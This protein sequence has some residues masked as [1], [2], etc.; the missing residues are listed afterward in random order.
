MRRSH[1]HKRKKI[2]LS[3]A[4][5]YRRNEQI[6]ASEVVVVDEK[7]NS[8]GQMPTMEAIRLGKESDCDLVEVSPKEHPPVARFMNYGKFLYQQE[9]MMK[10]QK[11]KQKKA[12]IKGIRLSLRIGKHDLEMRLSQAKEFLEDGQKVR[13]EMTLRGREKQYMQ[14]ARVILEEFVQGLADIAKVEMPFTKQE[15]RLTILVAPKL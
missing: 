8:L 4:E 1:H 2:S 10:R 5:Q 6:L 15:G 3:F 12:E 11:A 7:G 13:V 14:N 9:K